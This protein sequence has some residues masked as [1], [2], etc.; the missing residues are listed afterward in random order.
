VKDGEATTEG[1]NLYAK[2]NATVVLK[3]GGRLEG[4]KNKASGKSGG[5][6]HI[7][8]SGT[9]FTMG[10]DASDS[11]SV[12]GGNA[13]RWGGNIFAGSSA[14]L[15]IRGGEISGGTSGV[16][17]R[18]I[19][20]YDA[21]MTMTGGRIVSSGSAVGNGIYVSGT[22]TLNLG[23]TSKVLGTNNRRSGNI[24]INSGAKM[25]VDNTFVGDASVC[26][27]ESVANQN[28]GGTIPAAN[29]ICVDTSGT[30][31]GKL[32][33]ETIDGDP[34]IFGVSGSLQVAGTQ[35]VGNTAKWV[36]NNADATAAVQTGQYI[37]LYTDNSLTLNK[38]TYVDLN[39]H[40]LTVS[41]DHVLYGMDSSNDDFKG[42]GTVTYSGQMAAATT[43]PVTGKQ[44]VT[45]AENG[46]AT[47]H[48]LSARLTTVT[49]RPDAA[50]LYFKA[51]YQ[52][53]DTLAVLVKNYGVVLSV[54]NMPGAD[55]ATEEGD[56]NIATVGKESFASG[57]EATSTSVFGILKASRK[58]ELNDRYGK[59]PI[60]ANT[61]VELADGTIVMGENG[62]AQSLYDVLQAIDNN[63][64]DYKTQQTSILE[65][66]R[67]WAAQGLTSWKFENI[68]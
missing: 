14:H 1:G 12:T 44:Y 29:G 20:V 54:N 59:M 55:F 6:V 23:G 64:A 25:R 24:W 48:R 15:I 57:L 42:N 11:C 56:I 43:C 31:T 51:Q 46:T 63:W 61:Y 45:I 30:Y 53:D 5:S 7:T 36:A 10:A 37:K 49:L 27:A 18:N 47:F 28:Y 38:D 68:K 4:G 62:A 66:F 13:A 2:G 21:T 50:G 9:T 17:A 67:A 22:S 65:F 8:G 35:V 26:W 58:A 32:T 19:A 40:S 41:G 33:H 52:C 60:Y 34:N 39:G 16:A 3:N